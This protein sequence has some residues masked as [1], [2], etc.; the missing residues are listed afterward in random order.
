MPSHKIAGNPGPYAQHY[1]AAAELNEIDY[2]LSS[3]YDHSPMLDGMEL[4]GK[5]LHELD[6]ELKTLMND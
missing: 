6:P 2:D 4:K 3:S 5:F 1:R